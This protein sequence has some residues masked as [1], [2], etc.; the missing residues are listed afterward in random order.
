MIAH[1]DFDALLDAALPPPRFKALRATAPQR[2]QV[3]VVHADGTAENW[4]RSG[5]T[6]CDHAQEAAELAGLGGV[7]R[8]APEAA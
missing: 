3:S 8:V 2:F 4:Q 1:L 7:V 6:A 5:G